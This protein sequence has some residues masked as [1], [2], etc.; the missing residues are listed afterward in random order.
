MTQGTQFCYFNKDMTTIN[1]TIMILAALIIAAF[2][3][4]LPFGY[5]RGNTKKF[6]FKWFLYIH[7]P[8]P[9]IFVLRTLAGYGIKIVPLMIAGAVAGQIIGARFNK[10]RVS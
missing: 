1:Y 10:A 4:N 6:S 9:F 2:A 7:L 8:I 5:F 3:L